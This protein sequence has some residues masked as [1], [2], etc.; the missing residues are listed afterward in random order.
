MAKSKKSQNRGRPT[1]WT[2][3][4]LK[5]LALDTKY[6]HHGKKLTPSLLEQETKVGRNTW[7]RRMKDYINELNEP[8]IT[9]IP[10]NNNNETILPSV[11]VIFKKYGN[12]PL[13]L[14]NELLDFEILL[15]DFYKELQEYKKKEEYYEK[16]IA[17][18]ESLKAEIAKQK[19]RASHY[20][21]LYNNIV[22]SSVYP[23][24]QVAKG[25]QL[26]QLGI[27]KKLIDMNDYKDRNTDL[28]DFPMYFPNVSDEEKHGEEQQVESQ[29]QQENMVNLLK[30]FDI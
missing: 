26:H 27:K 16:S 29:K 15:Y 14:K 13:A 30:K 3:E 28:G 10:I 2:D 21:E 4:E 19:K 1:E 8:V 6:K 23:H 20:E 11:D 22:V 24:L 5:Q 9:S 18:I 25:S 12:D 17:E 7:S